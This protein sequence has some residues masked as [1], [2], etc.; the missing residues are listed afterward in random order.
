MSTLSYRYP[1]LLIALTICLLAPVALVAESEV[2]RVHDVPRENIQQLRR[3]GDF[4]GIDRHENSV[5][6]YVT[7]R[8]RAAVK[9]QGYE[10]SSDQRRTD[11]LNA[12]RDVDRADWKD[13]GMHGIPGFPCYRTV[14]ETHADLSALATANPDIARWE[15]IGETWLAAQNQPGGDDIYVLVIGNQQSPHP[16]APLL[17][18]GAQHARELTTAE[19]AARFAEWLL[20]GYETN[21]TARWLIDHREIHIVAQ[22]NPDGRRAVEQGESMWR[23]N[24][25]LNACPTG[26]PG[27]DLNRNS[28]HLWGDSSSGDTCSEIY[29]G[30]APGSEPETQ[31]IQDYMHEIFDQHWPSDVG[32]EPV[33]D[34]AAGMFLSLHS[35]SELILFPWDGTGSGPHNNA[36]NHDQLAWM[37]RKLGYF[38]GYEVGRDILYSAGGTTT[39]YAHS[40]FGVASYT[41]EIGTT[42]HQSCD[43]F[44]QTI[45]PY[46]L[47]SLIYAAK[48][49]ELPYLAPRGPDVTDFQAAFVSTS[50]TIEVSG[51]A[52]DTRYSR[53][54]VTEGP[55]NDPVHDITEVIAS[56]DV[57][58]HL[59]DTTI[60]LDLDSTGTVVSFSGGL[61]PD[62]WS[63]EPRLLFVQAINSEGLAGVVEATYVLERTADISP[64]AFSVTLPPGQTATETLAIANIGS[65]PLEWAIATDGSALDASLADPITGSNVA[66]SPPNGVPPECADPE[67][68]SWLSTSP[69][70]G[71]LSPGDDTTALVTI[72]T[73]ELEPGNYEAQLCVTTDDPTLPLAL[74]PLTLTVPDTTAMINGQVM[75]LGYCQT[76]PET[77][78]NALVSVAD[79][80][81]SAAADGNYNVQVNADLSPFDV[82]FNHPD[83][84][85]Q[86]VEGIE[87]KAGE[88]ITANADLVLREA[89][90]QVDPAA[91]TFTLIADTQAERMLTLS[92]VNGGSD[93]QWSLK[94]GDGCLDPAD[95]DW[96]ELSHT[97]GVIA[98]GNDRELTLSA[99][100]G[101][102][103]HGTYNTALCLTTDD[104]QQESIA[105]P[106]E[107]NVV[108][109]II[110]QD[111]FEAEEG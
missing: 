84:R 99:D 87:L 73:K 101:G 35:F 82:A 70:A 43:S 53:N 46:I 28:D 67:S 51:I 49:T 48:A 38:T 96:L 85:S 111:R 79:Q 86:Q 37:G 81:V 103:A 109:S 93:L 88:T 56:L 68:V 21:A 69:D 105:V 91:L 71:S 106:V 80:I 33:P 2:I 76:N 41:Y 65:T 58:P 9:A 31:A 92:N 98:W 14:D 23:K 3:L 64:D 52:D 107:L 61:S 29:R 34:D 78:A 55:E 25:N 66:L 17:I 24:S 11:A 4:W 30:V 13:R 40:Q 108:E 59:A 50:G 72:D 63:G 8:G 26:T 7:P 39:D 102:L 45:W 89:C 16:Q 15:S 27:V 54:G 94:G 74:V 20:E 42:F 97:G 62:Q 32:A 6:L 57:P 77:L 100:A 10:V 18:I 12:F 1:M 47:E 5:I 60:A 22:Q 110:F 83:H 104:A 44:E 36:P 90:A 19:S 75:S 95:N